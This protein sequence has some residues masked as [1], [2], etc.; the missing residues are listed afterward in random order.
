MKDQSL[1]VVY[2]SYGYT[3]KLIVEE[4]KRLGLKLML[5]GRNA[6]E[7]ELQSGQSGYPFVAVNADDSAALIKLLEPASVLI[8]CA[9]PFRHTAKQLVNACF[10]TGTHYTDITG[11]YEVFEL[12]ASLDEEA[13][14]HKIMV[15]PGTGFDV[16]PSDC[17]A[18]HLKG[19]LSSATRLQLAFTMSGGGLSRGTRKSMTEGLGYGG[20]I[21]EQGKL[22]R[23]PLGNETQVI[24]FGPFQTNTICIPWGDISTAWRSTGIPSIRVFTGT[25][26]S[27]IRNARISNYF[28]WLFRW[29]PFKQYLLRQ[30]DKRPPGPTAEKRQKGKSYLWG[31]VTNDQGQSCES[32]L[33]T[34]DG[35]SLTAKTALLIATRILAGNLKPGYQTPAMA[36]G[37]DLILAVEGS[38]RTDVN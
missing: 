6:R 37:A 11:E 30:V 32:R 21:R 24:D 26:D 3:G 18:L 4:A 15:M 14:R 38:K 13:R 29:R 36:Y 28:G 12:M 22:V 9:G 23:V 10:A 35:Y 31:K 5:S 20:R 1:I 8:H 33:E 34:I 19:R 7:L 25:T 17:L 16:V 27:M 2:G